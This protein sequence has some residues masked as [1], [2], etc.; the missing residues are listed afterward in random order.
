MNSLE[1]FGGVVAALRKLKDSAVG[2]LMRAEPFTSK[3]LR[4]W[5][6]GPQKVGT[7]GTP[8][9]RKGVTQGG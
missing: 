6:A 5:R 7:E 9:A 1:K 3:N 8:R 2:V 4:G